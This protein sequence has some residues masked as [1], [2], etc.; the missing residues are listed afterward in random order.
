MLHS[1]SYVIQCEDLMITYFYYF[2]QEPIV[3]INI[4]ISMAT[5][6]NNLIEFGEIS[7]QP[8]GQV[9]VDLL[10]IDLYDAKSMNQT[11]I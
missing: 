9:S 1:R 8:H 2:P 7:P 11:L 10:Q 6:I 3:Q 4:K 5:R